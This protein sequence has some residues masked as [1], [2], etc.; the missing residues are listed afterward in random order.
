MPRCDREKGMPFMLLVCTGDVLFSAVGFELGEEWHLFCVR[1]MS[2][3]VPSGLMTLR[4]MLLTSSGE[5]LLCGVRMY[6][7][8]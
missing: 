5:T 3:I 7:C 6:V 2:T 1:G 4:L 8:M